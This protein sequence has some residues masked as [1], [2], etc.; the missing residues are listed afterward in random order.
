MKIII[1][2]DCVNCG[3]VEYHHFIN[4]SNSDCDE[5]LTVKCPICGIPRTKIVLNYYQ[6]KS[7]E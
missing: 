4:K 5:Q 1:E 3:L 2:W 7:G 6:P